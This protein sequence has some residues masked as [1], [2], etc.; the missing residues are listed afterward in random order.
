MHSKREE[1]INVLGKVF[2]MASL[3][4]I[5]FIISISVLKCT[6]ASKHE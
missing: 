1:G 4:N 3:A 6:E 5:N 2:S